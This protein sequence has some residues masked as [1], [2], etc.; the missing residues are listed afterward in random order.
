VT[1]HASRRRKRRYADADSNGSDTA[2]SP[3]IDLAAFDEAETPAFAR[4]SVLPQPTALLVSPTT[5][6]SALK[7]RSS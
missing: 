7:T 6:S 2:S 1:Y 4:Q 3:T 5:R